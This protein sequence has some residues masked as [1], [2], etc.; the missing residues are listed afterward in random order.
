M[1]GILERN[2][3]NHG[4]GACKMRGTDINWCRVSIPTDRNVSLQSTYL[5]DSVDQDKQLP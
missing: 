4:N 5:R 2:R 3:R 1:L